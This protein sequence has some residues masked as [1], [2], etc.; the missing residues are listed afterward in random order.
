MRQKTWQLC[1]ARY[2]GSPKH[3]FTL[4]PEYLLPTCDKFFA[5]FNTTLSFPPLLE[6]LSAFCVDPASHDYQHSTID[7]EQ[8]QRLSRS[9]V[10]SGAAKVLLTGL[11]RNVVSETVQ[12][13][14][15]IAPT[16]ITSYMQV[17]TVLT[18]Q[19]FHSQRHRSVPVRV[20]AQL[21]FA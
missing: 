5:I 20:I 7:P 4:Y 12:H 18:R 15:F 19:V 2:Q 1:V 9:S 10:A 11:E 16:N 8:L 17:L 3:H 13:N 6:R 21:T 14:A